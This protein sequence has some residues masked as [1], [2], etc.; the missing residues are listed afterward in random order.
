[1]KS[2]AAIV[3]SLQ[4]EREVLGAREAGVPKLAH[5]SK[6]ILIVGAASDIGE[7]SVGSG[8]RRVANQ[9]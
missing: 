4:F 2:I 3:P 7:F 8:S 1:L 6:R 9:M 5:R